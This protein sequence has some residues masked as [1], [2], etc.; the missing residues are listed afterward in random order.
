MN[1]KRQFTKT[2]VG[3]L[4]LAFLGDTHA[5]GR[6]TKPKPKPVPRPSASSIVRASKASGGTMHKHFQRPHAYVVKMSRH[7]SISLTNLI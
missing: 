5:G 2:L 3:A 1:S 4:M 6:R 7:S